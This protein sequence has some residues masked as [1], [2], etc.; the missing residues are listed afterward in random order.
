M[1]AQCML[2]GI[3]ARVLAFPGC[4]TGLYQYSHNL[5]NALQDVD[6]TNRYRLFFNT[7]R[8]EFRRNIRNY[9][10]RDNFQKRNLAIPHRVAEL[11]LTRLRVPLDLVL[12]RIDLFHGLAFETFPCR[13]SKTVVTIHDTMF[14][15]DPQ[16]LP[17]AT[18]RR[19]A[20]ATARALSRATAVIANSE[21]TKR[22]LVGRYG[23]DPD[24]ISV[25]YLGI[26]ARFAPD[27]EP[28][29]LASV[30]R[31]YG[32]EKPYVLYFGNIE[33]KKNIAGIIDAFALLQRR[34][35]TDH[36]LVIAGRRTY[37]DYYRRLEE[38]ILERRLT[39]RV[40][41]TGVVPPD[42]VRYLYNG[43]DAFIFP[44]FYEGFG[45]PPLEAMACGIPAIVSDIPPLREV[46][47]GAAMLVDPGS[48]DAMSQAMLTVLTDGGTREGLVERGLTHASRFTW[49]EAARKT[50]AV[51][52]S[53]A[54][55]R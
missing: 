15:T 11:M 27:R 49:E 29:M 41:F 16:F 30:R 37:A 53:V 47:G 19:F 54:A 21:F 55:G 18:V 7:F 20:D 31:Q 33:P 26:D 42:D 32:I 28:E 5:L 45:M 50:V 8:G 52:E 44:S 6:G 1:R 46:C 12:G 39:G 35:K 40:I 48:P 3:D 38:Q 10:T 17:T 24:K 2:I 9:A 4:P 13:S 51:Y 34:K 22:E 36:V 23:T 25:I 43:A 14:I